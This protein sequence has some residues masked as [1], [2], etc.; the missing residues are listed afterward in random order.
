M[1]SGNQNQDNARHQPSRNLAL[2]L[3]L[4]VLALIA[5][6]AALQLVLARTAS[7]QETSGFRY[8]HWEFQNNLAAH[9]VRTLDEAN[10]LAEDLREF[11]EGEDMKDYQAEVRTLLDTIR[12]LEANIRGIENAIRR[13]ERLLAD[14]NKLSNPQKESKD[15]SAMMSKN[16]DE[17]S[18][19]LKVINTI[20]GVIS[21]KRGVLIESREIIEQN[22]A[23]LEKS[24][25]VIRKKLKLMEIQ[26]APTTKLYKKFLDHNQAVIEF[27]REHKSKWAKQRELE[28]PEWI[29]DK[30]EG[31]EEK[32][33]LEYIK[34]IF[35]EKAEK[36]RVRPEGFLSKL[37][38]FSKQM[39][40]L[41]ED[42]NKLSR[43]YDLRKF[44][45]FEAI[46]REKPETQN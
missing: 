46:H 16:L 33:V 19:N 9:Y 31:E 18:T 30:E 32:E 10:K 23:E 22:W 2:I 40:E 35:E 4:I 29:K 21:Q 42:F 27:Y 36:I 3:T 20:Q 7:A 41:K 8:C 26:D 45:E 12:K 25:K 5:Q 6:Y 13:R 37:A 44:G 39:A 15:I 24:H 1:N 43:K 11:F 17:K 14:W 34:Y 28:I 38:T